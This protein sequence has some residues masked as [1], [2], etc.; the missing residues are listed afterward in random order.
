MQVDYGLFGVVNKEWLEVRGTSNVES[1]GGNFELDLDVLAAP[2]G[3]EPALIPLMCCAQL[4]I[5]APSWASGD[6]DVAD[7]FWGSLPIKIGSILDDRG[8]RLAGLQDESGE[9]VVT[10][11]ARG[12]LW[13]EGGILKSRTVIKDQFVDLARFGGIKSIRTPFYEEI[14]PTVPGRAIGISTYEVE[15]VDGSVLSGT[16]IYPY[17]FA[18]LQSLDERCLLHVSDL[19]VNSKEFREMGVSPN[20]RMTLRGEK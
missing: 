4:Q 7:F 12:F 14:K 8:D 11:S 15:C 6:K 1:N 20:I 17:K 3:W 10:L 19:D 9:A 2:E 5:L 18:N 13:E 16:S